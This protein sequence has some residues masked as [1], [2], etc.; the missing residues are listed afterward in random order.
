MNAINETEQ[1]AKQFPETV[2]VQRWN[3]GKNEFEP[4]FLHRFTNNTNWESDLPSVTNLLNEQKIHD[5]FFPKAPLGGLTQSA[6]EK[7]LIDASQPYITRYVIQDGSNKI[8]GFLN[9]KPTKEPDI[10]SIGYMA[11]EKFR[12]VMTNTVLKII[13]ICR[14]LGYRK[15]VADCLA[16]N[17][18]SV[19]VLERAHFTQLPN[20]IDDKGRTFLNFEFLIF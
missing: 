19:H 20:T 3:K 16:S 14:G 9:I 11:S 17:S 4:C 15:I 5:V 10:I 8:V 1:Y 12:G 18:D 13:D 2:E 6:A 7:Y